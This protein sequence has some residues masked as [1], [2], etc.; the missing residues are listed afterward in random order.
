MTAIFTSI[1]PQTLFGDRKPLV[2]GLAVVYLWS[3]QQVPQARQVQRERLGLR[4]QQ[5]LKEAVV[6]SDFINQ[7][8][9]T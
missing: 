3:V 5:A 2:H 6:L 8:I 9:K 7:S 1:P 4:V